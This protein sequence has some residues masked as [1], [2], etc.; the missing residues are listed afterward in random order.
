MQLASG[1]Y[2][3]CVTGL[4]MVSSLG[5]DVATSCAAARAGITRVNEL[6]GLQL[7]DPDTAGVER[8]KGHA[9]FGATYGYDGLGRLVRL[10]QAGLRDLLAATHID[11]WSRIGL[12]L[13]LASSFYAIEAEKAARVNAD[14]ATS[15]DVDVL[16]AAEYREN[17]LRQQ[18]IPKIAKLVRIAIDPLHQRVFL[19]DQTGIIQMLREAAESLQGEQ[20]KGVIVG[21]IDSRLDPETFEFL[22][23]LGLLKT[24]FQPAGFIPGEMAAFVLLEREDTARQYKRYSGVGIEAMNDCSESVHR[25]SDEPAVG[26][27][28]SS[29]IATT[30]NS[31]TDKGQYTGLMIGDLNGDPYRAYDW[32]HALIRLKVNYPWVTLPE[33]YPALSFGEIGA[34]T[35][36]AAICLATRGFQRGYTETSN[37]LVWLSNDNGTRGAFY[38]RKYTD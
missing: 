36:L 27:A 14:T 10:G 34:A 30:L 21:G 4:G 33:W 5:H 31:L 16:A 38:I 29:T 15:D 37:I 22:N 8:A 6:D 11:D 28:L 17:K 7:L 2:G 13:N 32:G 25:F 9:V 18:L 19:G 12:F 20:L 24:P 1:H 3:L 35:G 26:I 23:R